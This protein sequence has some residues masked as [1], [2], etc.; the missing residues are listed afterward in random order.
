MAAM[1]SPEL[2]AMLPRAEAGDY[3]LSAQKATEREP[4]P[5]VFV[6]QL[7]C[8]IKPDMGTELNPSRYRDEMQLV[9]A[10]PSAAE[11]RGE[12]GRAMCSVVVPVYNER[13][14]VR[15]MYDALNALATAEPTLDWEFLFVEDGSTDDTFACLVDLNGS[16][17]RVK[18]ARL[19]R[20]YGSHV[21]AA[22]GLQ[23]ASGDV[24]VIIAA[25]L[26][27]HPREISRFLA[28]WREGFHVVWGVRATRREPRLYRF[29]A[30]LYSAVVRRIAL[31]NY[32]VMGTGSFCLL[33]RKVIDGL[34]SFPER[35]RM[36]FGLILMAGF[37][38][39]QIEYH[40]HER[41]AGVSK[42][43]TWQRIK[44]AIDTL[45]S[46]SPVPIRAVS[47]LGIVI[48]M[49]SFVYAGYLAVDTL[50]YGRRI[51]GWTTI[52]VLILMIGGFQLFVLGMFG[53]YLW[54]V[55]DE[56]RGRPLFLVQE[57]TGEFSR[58][59][60]LARQDSTDG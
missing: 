22:A 28:K 51:E 31:P 27:D 53:E 33:D 41:N 60:Q 40:R 39:T 45:V 57:L 38:Q 16:D 20:N 58:P 18:V 32:P 50:I 19:S 5:L 4:C 46:F 3:P 14:N 21:A 11:R 35:N 42:W 30:R 55:C 49:S 17:P 26:Q 44:V 6:G 34:N 9:R 10:L 43:S 13:D 54:R 47:V 56:V 24:A 48:A 52:I 15:A 37:R 25:D 8:A 29:L 59:R 7:D 1:N 36:T 2:S 23:L 12:A